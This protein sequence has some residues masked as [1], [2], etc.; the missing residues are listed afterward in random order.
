ME[1]SQQ[2]LIEQ[3]NSTRQGTVWD[4]LDIKIVKE[5]LQ[6][7]PPLFI[8]DVAHMFGKLKLAMKMGS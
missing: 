6:E 4:V 7:L 1:Q 2:E 3:I 8:W 5:W